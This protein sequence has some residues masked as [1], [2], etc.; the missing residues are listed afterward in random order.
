[1]TGMFLSRARLR[2]DSSVQAIAPLL[3]PEDGHAR[4]GAAHRLVWSLMSDGPGRTR[5]FLWREEQPGAFLILAPRPAQADGALF[6][7]ESKPWAPGLRRGDRLGFLLRANP[8]VARSPAP[9]VRGKRHDVVMDAL[10]GMPREER[11][12]ARRAAIVT[13]G[14]EWLARQGTRAGFALE[15][16]LLRID[17]YDTVRIPRGGSVCAEFGVLAFEGVLT[18][19]E[20]AALVA[21]VTCGLGRARAFGCGLMLLRRA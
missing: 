16:D 21:A 17:G 7:V 5:D 12:G 3:L 13:A 10:H 8:T 2:P 19:T 6:D 18:V 14:A 4:L 1:M 9:G 20:P 11:A 15:T